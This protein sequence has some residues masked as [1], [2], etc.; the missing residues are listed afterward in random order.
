M[1]KPRNIKGIVK[2]T[3]Y[4]TGELELKNINTNAT[5]KEIR[6]FLSLYAKVLPESF[7]WKE[8][9]SEPYSV[10]AKEEPPTRKP[11]VSERSPAPLFPKGSEPATGTLMFIVLSAVRSVPLATLTLVRNRYFQI[12]K[13]PVNQSNYTNVSVMLTKLIQRGLIQ[14]VGKGLYKAI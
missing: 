14:R 6:D 11:E 3:T 2:L 9:C 1:N 12:S 4:K 8:T 7:V 13:Q 10:F 5:D